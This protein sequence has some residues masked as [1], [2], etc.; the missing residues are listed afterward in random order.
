MSA[1][2]V[3]QNQYCVLIDNTQSIVADTIL[4]Y[5]LDNNE[6]IASSLED[7]I[8][9]QNDVNIIK[10][11]KKTGWEATN[12]SG[13]TDTVGVIN[14][15][16]E[17]VSAIIKKADEY[18]M[19]TFILINNGKEIIFIDNKNNDISNKGG[20]SKLEININSIL[21]SVEKYINT[22][23]EK[24]EKTAVA[25]SSKKPKKESKIPTVPAAGPVGPTETEESKKSDKSE[26]SK[27]PDDQDKSKVSEVSEV[28]EEPKAP[29]VSDK[30][31]ESKVSEVS[32]ESKVSEVSE[33]SKVSEVSKESEVPKVS[34]E[35]KESKKPPRSRITNIALL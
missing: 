17:S 12:V 2:K 26:V 29:K 31:E 3:S 10:I 18:P 8:S 14:I 19:I 27:V 24:N 22:M 15:I 30:S 32:E 35:S 7:I 21:T 9:T 28:S 20:R 13:V 4:Y 23:E 16:R 6:D 11:I 5:S 1:R 34:E 25:D 33:E